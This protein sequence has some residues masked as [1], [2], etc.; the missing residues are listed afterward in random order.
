METK[1][2]DGIPHQHARVLQQKIKAGLRRLPSQK[3]ARLTHR[4]A[5]LDP[6]EPTLNKQG[7]V[8]EGVDKTG[9]PRVLLTGQARLLGETWA[10]ER[11]SFTKTR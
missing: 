1:N 6:P 4:G 2:H 3:S 8:A 9:K 5:E 11:H 7:V 10:G